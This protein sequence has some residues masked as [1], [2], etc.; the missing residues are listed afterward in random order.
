MS[1]QESCSPTLV[2][3]SRVAGLS[4][5]GPPPP[6]PVSN[7]LTRSRSSASPKTNSAPQCLL[8]TLATSPPFLVLSFLRRLVIGQPFSTNDTRSHGARNCLIFGFDRMECMNRWPPVGLA[9]TDSNMATTEHV[10]DIWKAHEAH[11]AG[12]ALFVR[13]HRPMT[14]TGQTYTSSY[15]MGNP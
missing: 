11:E 8:P 4:G 14:H 15:N 7:H 12:I 6:R 3:R 2:A 9:L 10:V 13:G 1:Q 5:H